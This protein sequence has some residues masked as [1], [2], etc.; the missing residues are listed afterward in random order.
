MKLSDQEKANRYDPMLLAFRILV[1][2]MRARANQAHK[3][4]KSKDSLNAFEAYQYGVALTWTEAAEEIE[5]II[6]LE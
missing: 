4:V 1:D 5:R 6:T 3:L 2:S